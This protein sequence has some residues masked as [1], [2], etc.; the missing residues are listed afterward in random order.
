MSTTSIHVIFKKLKERFQYK[1]ILMYIS[2]SNFYRLAIAVLII[3]LI[4][5]IGNCFATEK[6]PLFL[7]F[8]STLLL[9]LIL[10]YYSIYFFEK[11]FKR[12]TEKTSA[13]RQ[14]IIIR[15]KHQIKKNN[16][17]NWLYPLIIA[18]S[19]LYIIHTLYKNASLDFF[20]RLYCYS[21]LYV[22]VFV[23]TIGYTQYAMFVRLIIKIA[24]IQH[25]ISTYDKILPYNTEWI[26]I[27]SDTAYKGSS[28]FFVVGLLYI[29]IFYVFSFTNIFG[30]CLDNANH[31]FWVS[32]FWIAIAFFIVLAFPCYLLISLKS[33]KRI[34]I[35]LKTQRKNNICTEMKYLGKEKLLE[36]LY[37]NTLMHLDNTPNYPEKPIIIGIASAGIGVVNFIASAQAC[38][39]LF[40]MIGGI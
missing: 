15:K 26:K 22:I 8:Q 39:A 32:L 35:M 20:M 3:A 18:T 30:I 10:S 29:G 33:I 36:Q 23:C 38:M 24:K 27:L 1:T 31:L 11:N 5:Q 28:M 34:V 9:I 40:Q 16:N 21:A 7:W 13:D 2:K 17:V 25:P 12:F 19:V 14:I 4:G 6:F 37:I